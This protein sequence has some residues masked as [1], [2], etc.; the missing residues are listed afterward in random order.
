MSSKWWKYSYPPPP[1]SPLLRILKTNGDKKL[2]DMYFFALWTSLST[3]ASNVGFLRSNTLDDWAILCLSQSSDLGLSQVPSVWT[4]QPWVPGNVNL[5][6]WKCWGK[7]YL[8]GM[9]RENFY[10]EGKS[11][12]GNRTGLSRRTSAFSSGTTANIIHFGLITINNSNS[13]CCCQMCSDSIPILANSLRHLP[14][15]RF[16]HYHRFTITH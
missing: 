6:L 15:L 16:Y 2:N 13:W 10:L 14:I 12:L 7:N 1:P 11:I 5:T 8:A 4:L 3:A 9:K